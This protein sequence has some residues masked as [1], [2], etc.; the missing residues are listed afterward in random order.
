MWLHAQITDIQREHSSVTRPFASAGRKC[1]Y[2]PMG[3]P[4]CHFGWTTDDA[5]RVLLLLATGEK[6][7]DYT[8]DLYYY[9]DAAERRGVLRS[10]PFLPSSDAGDVG[11]QIV[12]DAIRSNDPALVI[13]A[14]SEYSLARFGA[15]DLN[16]AV[17]KCVFLEIPLKE[18]DGLHD[19][20]NPK[21]SQMLANLARE[22]V[23]AGRTIPDDVWPIIS[24]F[25]PH[26][27]LSAIELEL[28]SDIENR[29]KAAEQ[30]LEGLA[31][32]SLEKTEAEEQSENI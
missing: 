17:L 6:A 31:A 27:E 26:A 12:F 14:I 13:A 9:G 7:W 23:L 1:G 18:I 11:M 29:R 4:A 16:Q 24:R 10:L 32:A 28:H 30:A 5:A 21:M 22:R 8:G 15:D 20:V 25:P 3:H 19:H 2:D